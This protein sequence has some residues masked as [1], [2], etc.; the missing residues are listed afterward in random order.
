M[1]YFLAFFFFSLS[2]TL[3]AQLEKDYVPIIYSG[4]VPADFVYSPRKAIKEAIAN[5]TVLDK[6]SA[7]FFYTSV[8]YDVQNMMT[9]GKVYFNDPLSN[10]LNEIASQILVSKPELSGKIKIFA[11]RSAVIN[12]ESWPNGYIFINIGEI[13]AMDNVH[14][15]AFT[16]AHEIA[17]FANKHAINSY[18]RE[19][20]IS[21]QETSDVENDD[22]DNYRTLRYSR[23]SEFEADAIGLQLLIA[24]TFDASESASSLRNFSKSDSADVEMNLGKYFNN[25]LFTI[26]TSWITEKAI[27]G[28]V[29][30]ATNRDEENSFSEN[31]EDIFLSHPDIEKRALALEEILKATDYKYSGTDDKKT[32]F[33]EM[34][35]IAAFEIVENSHRNGQYAFSIYQSIKLLET[36]PDNLFLNVNVMRSLYWL[37]HMREID[38]LDKVIQINGL[39]KGKNY[40]RL[41]TFLSKPGISEYKKL[42]YGFLKSRMEKLKGQD[43]FAFYHG[44]ITEQ[45]LGKEAAGVHYRAYQAQFPA[46][47]NINFVNRKLKNTL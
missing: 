13:N 37:C 9:G 45:Y 19:K 36:Y 10:Y 31:T 42:S 6:K 47:K 30:I 39:A 28:W 24:S 44:L 29:K 14:Q 25:E 18:K 38:A 46:G 7:R 41:N 40:D 33:D 22:G 12:A 43:D 17:H 8:Y 2:H 20:D 1:K 21:K 11:T 4:S 34:K 15:L 32:K 5:E 3:F 23:E 35:K 26:D 16:V 27:K